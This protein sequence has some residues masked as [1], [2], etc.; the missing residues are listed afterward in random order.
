MTHN[1]WIIVAIVGFVLLRYPARL[2]FNRRNEFG[3]EQFASYDHMRWRRWLERGMRL[4]GLFII[5][6]GLQHGCSTAR[7]ASSHHVEAAQHNH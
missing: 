4:A 6:T 2:A 7:H 3:V 5:I 1:L